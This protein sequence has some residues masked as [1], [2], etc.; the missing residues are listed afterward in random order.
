MATLIDLALLLFGAKLGGTLFSKLRQPSVVGELIAGVIL[1]PSVLA[2]VN[3]SPLVSAISELGLLFL[4]LTVSLSINWKAL[5][6]S[7]EKFIWIELLRTLVTLGVVYALGLFFD[8]SLMT[9]L[10][11]GI[12]I[13]LSSTSIVSRTLADLKQL[14]TPEGQD[15]I[16]LEIVDEVVAIV[17]VALLANA[18]SG[19]GVSVEP[20]LTTVFVVVGFFVVMGRV[21]FKLVNRLT[22][23]IQKYGIEEAL[24]GFTLL[25]AFVLG[26]ITES[27][28]LSSILGVFMAGMVLSRSAQHPLVNRKVKEIGESFF[29]PLFFASVG[30]TI[31]LASASQQLPAIF[32][33]VVSIIGIKAVSTMVALKFF[34]YESQDAVKISTGFI[35]LSEMTVV[36]IALASGVL[37]PA[38][39]VNLL[40]AFVIISIVSPVFIAG[41][42]RYT[43][44]SHSTPRL[45]GSLRRTAWWRMLAQRRYR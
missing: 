37:D 16:G 1:G 17:S 5:E 34:G 35:T 11:V 26:G 20:L 3:S 4:I 22:A 31:N 6:G 19:A 8:W 18:L 10:V 44:P 12:I 24:L 7:T 43:F 14:G 39:Y 32:W 13:V 15:L 41:A 40:T 45:I 30:L 23:S 2:L 9:F 27:L 29:I 36:I 28:E 21:G 25:L 38:L 33:L 42:F